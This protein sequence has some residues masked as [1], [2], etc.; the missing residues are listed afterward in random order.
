MKKFNIAEILSNL[1][2]RKIPGGIG[3]RLE[4]HLPQLETPKN[5]N[6]IF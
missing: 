5:S 3:I 2:Y 1:Q 4:N 6:S